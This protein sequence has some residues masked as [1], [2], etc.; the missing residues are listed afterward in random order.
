MA[1]EVPEGSQ[2]LM[3]L[4]T[5]M[6]ARNVF[7]SPLLHELDSQHD[8]SVCIVA[9]SLPDDRSNIARVRCI[10]PPSLGQGLVR[11]APSLFRSRVAAR[12]YLSLAYRFNRA[13]SFRGFKER[14]EM[15]PQARRRAV[16]AGNPASRWLGFPFPNG[17]RTYKLLHRFLSSGLLRQPAIDDLF[18]NIRPRLL[19]LGHIQT[20]LVIPYVLAARDRAIPVL[21]MVGSWD[22]PS[23]K[24]PVLTVDRFLVQSSYVFGQLVQHHGIDPDAMHI[25][26]AP[27]TDWLS[28]ESGTGERGAFLSRYGIPS[29][30]RIML[31]GTNSSRLGAHEFEILALLAEKVRGGFF[32]R[33]WTLMIRPHP[34]DLKSL[35]RFKRLEDPP[36]VIVQEA[37]DLSLLALADVITH[38]DVVMSSAGSLALDAVADDKCA[39]G[40]AFTLDPSTPHHDRPERMYEMEHNVS[41]AESEAIWIARDWDRLIEGIQICISEP[42]ARADARRRLRHTHLEPLDGKASRRIVDHVSAM[43]GST[44]SRARS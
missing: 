8:V 36:H 11:R 28:R 35:D 29:D 44:K 27:Q 2:V 40:I 3:Y 12:I 16:S 5:H 26:G 31:F 14:L 4:P 15:S 25:V 22:Q 42:Q 30:N 24:G 38:S 21:G 7:E 20:P 34:N 19:V 6:T 33:G 39:I 1:P 13:H 17:K 43:V 18:D 10:Y 23:T 32:G 37:A 9:Q 41:I